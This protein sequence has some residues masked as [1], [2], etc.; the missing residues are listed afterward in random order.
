MCDYEN[1]GD[2]NPL[3]HGGIWV[4]QIG[5][6]IFNIVG[7]IPETAELYNVEVDIKSR[8]IDRQEVTAV[9][10]ALCEDYVDPTWFAIACIIYYGAHDFGETYIYKTEEE[11]IEKLNNLGIDL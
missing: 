2:A 4:K 5:Y 9:A 11:L 7:N 1:Y 6:N 3:K 8:C 10:E